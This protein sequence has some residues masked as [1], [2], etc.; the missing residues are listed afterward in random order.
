MPRS[1]R[2]RRGIWRARWKRWRH[3]RKWRLGRASVLWP[4]PVN[5]HGNGLPDLPVKSTRRRVPALE[6]KSHKPAALFLSPEAPYPIAGGG[7]LAI[8]F[9]AGISGGPL[10]RGC[11]RLPPTGGARSGR[12]D[13]RPAGSQHHGAGSAQATGAA[14]PRGH[15]AMRGGWCGVCRRWSTGLRAFRP[16][17]PKRWAGG[18][19]DIG[20]IEHSWCA[21]YLE[22]IPP[23][24]S[25]TVLDLHNVE[26]VLHARCAAT[27][28]RASA[29]AHRVFQRVSEKLERAW[30]PRFSLVLATSQ[31]RC[32][33]W[34][35]RSHRMPR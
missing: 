23:V 11:D 14:S 3:A 15:C 31:S 29:A 24:C 34:S 28:G 33:R 17:S 13:S 35:A 10:R 5:S 27:E 8:G 22:Q 9:T 12:P 6:H 7:S 16:P 32:R 2:T 20:V 19:Y 25:R 1:T 26:S 18:H 4:A 21:P 30:L